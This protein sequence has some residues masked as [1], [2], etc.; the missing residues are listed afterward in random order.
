MT[1][2]LLMGGV[3][4]LM[5]G[6]AEAFVT[7]F[8]VLMISS[9]AGLLTHIPANL[10]VLE[11]VFVALLAGRMGQGEVLAGVL[12]YRAVYYLTPLA[13]ATVVYAVTEARTRRARPTR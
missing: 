9:V 3:A 2:W 10:G 6:R 4:W 1:N 8:C 5:L 13:V 7:V 12:G 11:A